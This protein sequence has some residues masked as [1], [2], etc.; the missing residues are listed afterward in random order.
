M[1]S[2]PNISKSVA[3]GF[4]VLELFRAQRRPLTAAQIQQALAIPQPSA[5][6]LLKEMVEI[7]YLA[8]TMPAK[9]Y[10]P[11]PRVATLGD[12]LGRNL[13]V[14]EPLIRIVDAI[15]REVGETTT[16]STATFGHVEVLYVRRAEHVLSLQVTA[17][18][19]GTLWRSATGRTLLSTRT[20]AELDEFFNSLE[21]RE[22]P[23]GRRLR[24]R[25]LRQIRE[26]RSA[27]HF[28]GYDVFVKG[29]GVLCMPVSPP[30]TSL[31]LVLSVAGDKERIQPREK[32][33]LRTMRA[34]LRELFDH[35]LR[36]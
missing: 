1:K 9:T 10:F 5:R 35:R 16:L 21:P 11:T 12:W 7:G 22:A 29:V 4:R 26:I 25:I 8:Y 32:M 31:P 14:H 28:P 6:V 13:L 18:M 2:Q 27:G 23:R 20:D 34:Q 19:G 15:S 30:R 24:E 3:R 36:A 33:I 17:G